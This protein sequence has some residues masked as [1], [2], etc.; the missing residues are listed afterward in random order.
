MIVGI[1]IRILAFSKTA[2]ESW[3]LFKMVTQKKVRTQAAISAILSVYGI[4]LDGE[5]LQIEFFLRKKN[6]FP[7]CLRNTF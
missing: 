7:S 4:W 2:I 6:N 5:K 3:Y 1:K